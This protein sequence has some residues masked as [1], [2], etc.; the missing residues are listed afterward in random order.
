MKAPSA[1][2][3]ARFANLVNEANHAFMHG[4]FARANEILATAKIM[5]RDI[6]LEAAQERQQ[7]VQP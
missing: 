7:A 1:I 4:D 2:Q 5:V 6:Y 3:C